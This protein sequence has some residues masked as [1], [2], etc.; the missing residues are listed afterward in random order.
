[1]APVAEPATLDDVPAIAEIFFS[2]FNDDYFQP[3]FPQTLQGWTYI[4]E[5]Y[6][7]FITGK[8]GRQK[9]QVFVIRDETGTSAAF[10]SSR[11]VLLTENR[12][13]SLVD[14]ILVCSTRGQRT[15]DLGRSLA[16]T[17]GDNEP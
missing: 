7:S 10:L 2:G 3:V 1:M 4:E 15:V 14:S 8:E 12:K 11:V 5:A 9:S 17:K 6:A 13:T 16:R